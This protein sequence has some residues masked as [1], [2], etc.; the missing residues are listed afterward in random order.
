[1]TIECTCIIICYRRI[2][3]KLNVIRTCLKSFKL[4]KMHPANPKRT[5]L[6]CNTTLLSG[7]FN[8]HKKTS[9]HLRNLTKQTLSPRS[10]TFLDV[11]S[12]TIDNLR[13]LKSG[14]LDQAHFFHE[15]SGTHKYQSI[16]TKNSLLALA[17]NIGVQVHILNDVEKKIADRDNEKTDTKDV[18]TQTECDRSFVVQ[19]TPKEEHVL[20]I[21]ISS[22]FS[23]SVKEENC[24]MT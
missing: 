4:S 24:E 5:C 1:M 3:Y 20:N 9:K 16:I 23:L 18:T 11:I 13:K 19:V 2:P 21:P 15:H 17:A 12:T 14:A 22:S 7:Y 10:S 6:V 8:K